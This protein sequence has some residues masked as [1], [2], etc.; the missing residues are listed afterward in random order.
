MTPLGVQNSLQFI[1]SRA[2]K[3]ALERF[4]N[5]ADQLAVKTTT[6]WQLFRDYALMIN[7]WFVLSWKY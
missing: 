4:N 7:L 3:S 6:G 1:Y 5:E 2:S